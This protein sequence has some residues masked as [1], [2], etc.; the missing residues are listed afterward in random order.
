MAWPER[1]LWLNGLMAGIV[2][3]GARLV[4]GQGLGGAAQGILGFLLVAWAWR[5]GVVWW[6]GWLSRRSAFWRLTSGELPSR[7]VTLSG[8][9]P[10]AALV[11]LVLPTPFAQ[12]GIAGLFAAALFWAA[13]RRGGDWPFWF[14]AVTAGSGLALVAWLTGA[15]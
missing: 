7:L 13:H 10:L 8:V 14:A 12:M 1:V 6:Y 5:A 11:S 15:I 9:L 3:A 4:S 2:V